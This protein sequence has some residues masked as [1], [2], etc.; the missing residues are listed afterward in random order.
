MTDVEQPAVAGTEKRGPGRPPNSTRATEVRAQ[1]RRRA[2]TPE[3]YGRLTVNHELLD[4]ANYAYRWIN[5]AP[6]RIEAKT[7]RDDWDI[8]RDPAIKED[9]N[10]EGAQVRQLV[11]ATADGKPF[12]AYLCKKPIEFHREDRVKKQRALDEAETELKRGFQKDP[13]A[14]SANDRHAY[15]PGGAQAPMV[16]TG[17]RRVAQIYTP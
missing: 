15:I 10:N 12:Y 2:D 17:P 11:G 6:G 9:G 14:L 7:V 8:L 13:N 16:L 4:H 3:S 1:R 5:D